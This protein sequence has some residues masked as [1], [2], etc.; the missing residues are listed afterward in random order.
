MKRFI[1]TLLFALMSL[2]VGAQSWSDL[3]K[4]VASDTATEVLDQVTGGKLTEMALNGTWN[5]KTPT[6]RF[7]SSNILSSIGGS[8]MESTLTTRLEKGYKLVGIQEGSASFTFNKDK[9]FRAVL[10]KKSLEGTYTFDNATHTLTLHFSS[11]L[12]SS[13]NG[14][15]YIDGSELQLVFPVTKLVELVKSVGKRISYLQSVATMLEK[16]DEVYLGF[17]FTKQP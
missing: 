1:F 9:T 11:K 13:M 17:G 14:R 16:Y 12:L 2:S 15:A 4:Q 10:G 3:L 7:E 5:Y 8:A 6:V